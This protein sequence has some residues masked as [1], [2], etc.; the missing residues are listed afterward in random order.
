MYKILQ[1][2]KPELL[3]QYVNQHL[4]SG[5]QLVGG[6]SVCVSDELKKYIYIQAVCKYEYNIFDE[7]AKVEELCLNN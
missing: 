1:S 4:K 5:Y 7:L 2:N 6:V 3:E